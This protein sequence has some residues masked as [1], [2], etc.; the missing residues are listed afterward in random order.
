L[1]TKR[2]SPSE[3][4]GGATPKKELFPQSAGLQT[5]AQCCGAWPAVC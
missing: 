3:G 2:R 1:Q 4:L 5:K